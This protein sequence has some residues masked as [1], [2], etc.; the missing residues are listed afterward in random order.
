MK[1]SIFL[2]RRNKVILQAGTENNSVAYT[3]TLL[4][5]LE[6]LG[7]TLSKDLIAV[8][9]T[10]SKEELK[11][12]YLFL[13]KDLKSMLGANV[14][15]DPIYP[16]FPDQ[17]M[18]LSNAELY[19]NAIIHYLTLWLPSY[20]KEERPLLVDDI[21]LK[22]IQLGTEDEFKNIISN[23]ISA[24]SSLSETDKADIEWAINAY[25][26]NLSDILPESIPQKETIAFIAAAIL[27]VSDNAAEFLKPYFK[28]ATDLL[29]LCA[30][31]SD[32]DI[33]L[34][35]QTKFRN[36]KRSE[37]R[38]LLSLLE[39]ATNI[40]EDMLRFKGAWLRL[41]EILHP[42]EFQKKFPKSFEA[43]DILRNDLEFHSFNRHI[44]V[45]LESANVNEAVDKLQSRPGDFA[46]RL[47]HLLRISKKEEALDLLQRFASV[48]DKVSTPVLLQVMTHFQHRYKPNG[49]RTY[50]PKGSVA[51]VRQIEAIQP[52][53]S[54]ELCNI[55]VSSC[56]Q[57]LISKF[58]LLPSLGSVYIAPELK[59]HLVPFS[60]RSASKALRT[61]VRGSRIDMPAGDTIRFFLWW[62]EGKIQG[63]E[64]GRVDIDLSSILFSSN[65][66]YMEHISYTNLKSDKYRACHS[67]DITSAPEGACEFIDI[68]IPSAISYGGRYVM[69]NVNAFTSHPYCDLPEC[70]AGW[71]MRQ[72]PGSGEIFEPK[73]VVNKID[74]TAD[75]KI[76]IPMI[77]DLEERQLIW[78]DIALNAMPNMNI[79]IESNMSGAT[80]MGIAMTN[81]QKTSLYD[82]FE[83]HL[84]ARG[85]SAETANSADTVFSLDKGITP[86]D[87]EQ[88]MSEFMA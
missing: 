22:V 61:L 59:Q 86:Y 31:L 67:G 74:L 17:L 6:N 14:E 66:R 15:Y 9:N 72:E 76:C 69:M 16:N 82:L 63:K 4:K 88:I 73:T 70:F 78:T 47:D 75:T 32:G 29:R 56:R 46:R 10:Q 30:A 79:N 5:N 81:L 13:I 55:A 43:F 49:I 39:N 37:R 28:T 20:E 33:S 2:R 52:P 64:T 41:G 87:I 48:A 51:K 24:N 1:N 53:L 68:D 50:F 60:Q 36:F 80:L 34:A 8:I 44:E 11:K 62:K 84:Q 25:S 58:S 85:V 12:T 21:K 27:K 19:V 7:Y 65:W 77:I 45:A 57:A 54:E 35:K 26:A 40:T 3:G 38:F 83:L 18:K 23:L 71:M 42:G